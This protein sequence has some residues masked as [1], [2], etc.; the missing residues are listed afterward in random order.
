VVT[1]SS[2]MGASVMDFLC[3]SQSKDMM[4]AVFNRFVEWN[5]DAVAKVQSF[6]IDKD[7]VE[8]AVLQEVFPN[9]E[10][11]LCQFHVLKWFKHV[12]TKPKYGIPVSMRDDVMDILRAL[13]YAPSD[14]DYEH[15]K[16]RLAELLGA[17]QHQ[18]FL[19]YMHD[20]W[21]SCSKMWSN[22][23]RGQISPP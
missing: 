14:E 7:Y 6:V 15:N 4:R 9:S 1:T 12:I 20:R 19:L 8:W 2:G 21:Y 16:V 5:P 13:V 23:G 10:V 22:G 17:P 11:V 18:S 3:L